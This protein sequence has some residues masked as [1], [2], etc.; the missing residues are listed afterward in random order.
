LFDQLATTLKLVTK[1]LSPTDFK[2]IVVTFDLNL[3]VP[4]IKVMYFTEKF[5]N[6]HSLSNGR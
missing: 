3:L 6:Y 1:I 5:I 2:Q 4:V